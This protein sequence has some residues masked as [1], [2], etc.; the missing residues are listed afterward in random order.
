[1]IAVTSAVLSVNCVIVRGTVAAYLA[2]LERL[3]ALVG[4]V[5]HIVPGHGPVTD[6]ARAL[7]VIQE[8]V[9]Y[10]EQLRG[11]G[12]EAELP[13]GR[14]ARRQR[15]IHAENVCALGGSVSPSSR[16]N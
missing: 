15:A 11:R 8:D 13:A 9:A 6:S 4:E 16:S 10:L 3:R 12:A 5:E 2:T 7:A 1:M 14:R